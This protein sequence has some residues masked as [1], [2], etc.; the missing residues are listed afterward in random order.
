MKTK[1]DKDEMGLNGRIK[2]M[3]E[4]EYNATINIWKSIKKK[5]PRRSLKY[6]FDSSGNIV[7][8]SSEIESQDGSNLSNQKYFYNEK[9]QKIENWL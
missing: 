2:A 5:S 9:S 1:T 6:V 7:E 8:S 4:I 3:R